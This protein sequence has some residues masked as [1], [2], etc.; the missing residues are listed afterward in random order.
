MH[1]V[2]AW[3]Y[4]TCHIMVDS[5]VWFGRRRPMTWMR[6]GNKSLFCCKISP[7]SHFI[8]LQ[9]RWRG[10]RSAGV[11]WNAAFTGMT[12]VWDSQLV[13]RTVHNLREKW[14][15]ALECR[16][17]I[18]YASK[19]FI[20][21]HTWHSKWH[22]DLLS[23]V[24]MNDGLCAEGVPLS[25]CCQEPAGFNMANL[26]S[27]SLTCLILWASHSCKRGQQKKDDCCQFQLLPTGRRR[28]VMEYFQMSNVTSAPALTWWS[29]TPG[30]SV[31]WLQ[32]SSSLRHS[33]SCFYTRGK[34]EHFLS[35]S[36]I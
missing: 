26:S 17:M 2:Y 15:S 19:I 23:C 9:T 25:S 34:E 6:P 35:V 4:S 24:G 33:F 5:T 21:G 14:L 18:V 32:S 12:S 8:H 11:V 3:V 29:E 16:Q 13:F 31:P 22:E 28:A 7:K 27:P 20:W 36:N 1:P 10:W 30:E